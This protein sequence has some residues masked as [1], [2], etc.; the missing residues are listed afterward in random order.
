MKVSMPKGFIR[1]E[2]SSPASRTSWVERRHELDPAVS[3][4][5]ELVVGLSGA[6]PSRQK[7]A[8]VSAPSTEMTAPARMLLASVFLPGEFAQVMR[9]LHHSC[10]DQGCTVLSQLQLVLWVSGLTQS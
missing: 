3:S 4:L 8:A 1:V 10:L 7:K 2:L 9:Y 6:A 5:Y